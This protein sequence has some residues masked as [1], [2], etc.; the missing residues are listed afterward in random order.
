MQLPG[1]WAR[2]QWTYSN[3]L[4]TNHEKPLNSI[5]FYQ[6]SWMLEVSINPAHQDS[7]RPTLRPAAA[8]D[9]RPGNARRPLSARITR[10]VET[11][12][13]YFVKRQNC[14]LRPADWKARWPRVIQPAQSLPKFLRLSKRQQ[15]L[16]SP[17][18]AHAPGP[19]HASPGEATVVDAFVS[20]RMVSK[21]IVQI[22][23]TVSFRQ[24]T[25]QDLVAVGRSQ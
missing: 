5:Q 12:E 11:L 15:I 16:K 10:R 1:P 20:W 2:S 7:L 4:P 18:S 22:H 19:G 6:C 24:L 14:R 23:V 25:R 13:S 21:W 8:S 17:G 9:T 3:K